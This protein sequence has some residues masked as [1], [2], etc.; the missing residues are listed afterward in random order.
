MANLAIDHSPNL[1]VEG[2][3]LKPSKAAWARI[4]G[5]DSPTLPEQKHRVSHL[6]LLTSSALDDPD[7]LQAMVKETVCS[8]NS[9]C[10]ADSKLEV[11]ADNA[12]PNVRD[13]KENEPGGDSFAIR[14]IFT[15]EALNCVKTELK[16]SKDTFK[17]STAF[18]TF[19]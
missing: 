6:R 11:A 1:K 4:S 16:R 9:G 14:W 12:F 19:F 13:N 10:V 15:S 18:G 2:G 17:T 5:H 3:N 7:D 8:R